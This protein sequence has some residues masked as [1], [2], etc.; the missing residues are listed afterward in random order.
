MMVARM[1]PPYPTDL[2][3]Q[4][5][6][7]RRSCGELWTKVFRIYSLTP[8]RA[9]LEGKY[10]S[11]AHTSLFEMGFKTRRSRR[12]AVRQHAPD[13]LA[14]PNT[15]GNVGNCGFAESPLRGGAVVPGRPPAPLTDNAPGPE[16]GMPVS[17]FVPFVA[18]VRSPEL[19]SDGETVSSDRAGRTVELP[20]STGL[21]VF[22]LSNELLVFCAGETVAVATTTKTLSPTVQ[23]D[24]RSWLNS[25]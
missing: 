9:F 21:V 17:W 3:N 11:V 7:F 19:G 14:W 5:T 25:G 4:I 20:L 13:V 24:L 15:L 16:H 6:Y 2:A 1:M 8:W 10:H 22:P 12:R 18:L 23:G